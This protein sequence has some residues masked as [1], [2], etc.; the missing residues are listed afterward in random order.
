MWVKKVMEHTGDLMYTQGSYNLLDPETEVHGMFIN[1]E[2]YRPTG[3]RNEG[4]EGKIV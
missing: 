3:D 2:G 1:Q 4:R